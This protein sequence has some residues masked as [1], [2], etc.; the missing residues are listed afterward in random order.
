MNYSSLSWFP[1]GLIDIEEVID[2]D[3]EEEEEDDDNDLDTGYDYWQNYSSE[4]ALYDALGGEME[5]VWNID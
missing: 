4:E 3:D 2:I 5:A 1:K